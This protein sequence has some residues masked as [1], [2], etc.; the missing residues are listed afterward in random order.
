[1]RPHIWAVSAAVVVAGILLLLPKS[2]DGQA[3][4]LTAPQPSGFGMD[5]VV[6]GS[7]QPVYRLAGQGYIEGRIGERYTIRLYNHT[8]TRVE[9]VVSVDG[10]DAMDGGPAQTGKR[11]YVLGPYASMEIDGFRL[12]LDEVA[13]FRFTSVADSYASRMGSSWN[14]GAVQAS[15]FPERIMRPRPLRAS[16]PR[17]AGASPR[18][19]HDPAQDESSQ[20]LGTEFG[21][22]RLSQVQETT[23]VRQ[24]PAWPAARLLL[25]YNDRR[26]L[27]SMGINALCDRAPWTPVDPYDP[28][29]MPPPR[30]FSSPPPGWQDPP[31]DR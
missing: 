16:E 9:A 24:N 2:V 18:A 8:Y 31:D 25:R 6:R 19:R 15:F 14:I 11:G 26:G 12:S 1:M 30:R 29:P 7:T 27:C 23:F 17:A 4:V 13:A 3:P 21:E 28:Y 20:N 5:I 22:R 10:R